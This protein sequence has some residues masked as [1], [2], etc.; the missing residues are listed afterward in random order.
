MVENWW[1]VGG[2]KWMKLNDLHEPEIGKSQQVASSDARV[3]M[4]RIVDSDGEVRLNGGERGN[5]SSTFV[6]GLTPFDAIRPC[7]DVLQAIMMLPR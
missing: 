3:N 6:T 7:Q 4:Q 5:P 1:G 2:T